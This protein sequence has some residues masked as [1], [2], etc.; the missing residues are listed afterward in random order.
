MC[1]KWLHIDL[2][3]DKSIYQISS[4]VSAGVGTQPTYK[5]KYPTHPNKHRI[6]G[7]VLMFN[8]LQKLQQNCKIVV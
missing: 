5:P 4:C 1:R 7:W 2:D 3:N 6:K 8:I